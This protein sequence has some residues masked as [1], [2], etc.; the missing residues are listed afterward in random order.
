MSVQRNF[1]SSLEFQSRILEVKGEQVWGASCVKGPDNKYHLFFSQWEE[2]APHAAWVI[3]CKVM[4]AVA[5]D[6]TGP[7]K[8]VGTALEG[9]G[10]DAWDAWTIHNPTVAEVDGKYVL[11]Y[12]GS[13]GKNIEYTAQELS[14]LLLSVEENPTNIP[15]DN[16]IMEKFGLQNL[17]KEE[18]DNKM[19]QAYH[20]VV[21]SQRV[22]MAIADTPYG[23]WQRV[24]T[25]PI[26]DVGENNTWDSALTSN[27]AFIKTPDNRY[28]IYYKGCNRQGWDS[29]DSPVNRCYGLAIADNLE[30]P[31]IK[32]KEN[33]TID[34]SKF[35]KNAQLED[36]S[37]F[38]YKD[39]YHMIARDMGMED[40]VR[41]IIMSSDDGIHFN[42]PVKSYSGVTAYTKE[43]IYGLG[44]EGRYERPQIYMEDGKPKAV[45]MAAVGGKYKLSTSN[46]FL[47]NLDKLDK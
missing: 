45:F 11:L 31:Y 7:Y 8:V 9:Q 26:I 37:V 17:T 46:L 19:W 21:L 29:V 14:D 43:P 15:K 18:F 32:H 47:I 28:I 5:D 25:T 4:H 3:S 13:S 2:D 22:G 44:R 6:I 1:A 40:H 36:A 23:P 16:H 10:G 20:G 30:G 35:K 34:Y 41:G 39:Q 33:P 42:D 24:G 27:P 38:F 12:L